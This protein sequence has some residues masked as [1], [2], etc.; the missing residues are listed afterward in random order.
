MAVVVVVVMLHAL[1]TTTT[2][3]PY[4]AFIPTTSLFGTEE[5]GKGDN[6]IFCKV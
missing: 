2:N 5:E 3:S 6:S 4:I 1:T